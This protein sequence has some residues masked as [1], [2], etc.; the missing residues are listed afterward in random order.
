MDRKQLFLLLLAS[1]VI[2]DQPACAPQIRAQ[3][4]RRLP[5]QRP[6]GSDD[7]PGQ[8]V[9]QSPGGRGSRRAASGEHPARSA[10]GLH[11]QMTLEPPRPTP[12]HSPAPVA[13]GQALPPAPHELRP[14]SGPVEDPTI[15]P[16]RSRSSATQDTHWPD[17][18]VATHTAYAHQ[19]PPSSLVQAARTQTTPAGVVSDDQGA[20]APRSPEF[21]L[22]AFQMAKAIRPVMLTARAIP[23]GL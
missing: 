12:A 7:R 23:R 19:R 11:R 13:V 10:I 22:R 18:E 3:T 2:L 20:D 16:A 15:L 6:G 21:R 8:F 5:G 1:L 14:I 4:F 9:I 17:G